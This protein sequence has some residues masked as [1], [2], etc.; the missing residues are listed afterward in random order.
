MRSRYDNL[1]VASRRELEHQNP[2]VAEPRVGQ[3]QALVIAETD[4]DAERIARRA[5]GAYTTKLDRAHGLVPP[6]LQGDTV[7]ELD[8]PLAK[9]MMA[10]DPL[11]AEIMVA[12]SP[13]TV[14]DYYVEQALHGIVNYFVLMTPFGDMSATEAR[15]TLDAFIEEVIPAVRDVETAPANA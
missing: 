8:N 1:R 9:A 6:H 14:R 15:Y 5:W 7:P 13:E 12:G 2:H 4:E 11:E 10:R 3:S